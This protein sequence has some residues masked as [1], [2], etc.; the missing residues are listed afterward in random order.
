MEFSLMGLGLALFQYFLTYSLIPS[1]RRVMYTLYHFLLKVYNLL[2]YFTEG[3][4]S[5]ETLEI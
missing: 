1:F 3:L 2:L 5:Q 4:E